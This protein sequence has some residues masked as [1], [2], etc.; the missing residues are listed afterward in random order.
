MRFSASAIAASIAFLFTGSFSFSS[1][2]VSSLSSSASFSSS[3][4]SGSSSSAASFGLMMFRIASFC[5]SVAPERSMSSSSGAGSLISPSNRSSSLTTDSIS[6]SI[7]S[8]ASSRLLYFF[9]TFISSFSHVGLESLTTTSEPALPAATSAT[10]LPIMS[11][12]TPSYFTP[13]YSPGVM[14]ARYRYAQEISFL[15]SLSI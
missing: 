15:S 9:C 1:S 11:R 12:I 2:S 6:A 5:S 14:S 7:A 3:F 8:F 4:F 10:W 13:S